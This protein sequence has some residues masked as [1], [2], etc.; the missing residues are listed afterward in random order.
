MTIGFILTVDNLFAASLP[1]DVKQNAVRINKEG[2]FRMSRDNN[3]FSAI[4][5]R[6]SDGSGLPGNE[7]LNFI[8]NVWFY[9]L[10]NFQVIFYNYFGPFA[11]L[12]V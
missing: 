3:K 9:I 1:D 4:K 6:Y 5:Q 11:V 7:V 2:G 10:I 12:L 8:V